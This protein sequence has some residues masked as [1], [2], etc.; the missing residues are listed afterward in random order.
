MEIVN[1]SSFIESFNP[2][3]FKGNNKAVYM[4]NSGVS[5]DIETTSFYLDNNY[6]VTTT[7]TDTKGCNMYI[8]TMANGDI[9]TKGRYWSEL[10]DMLTK[11]SIRL[12]LNKKRKLIIYCHNLSYEFQFMRAYFK[13]D[14]VFA[15]DNR[16]PLS[17]LTNEFIEFRCSYLLTNKSLAKLSEETKY[18]KLTGDLNYELLRHS[19][20]PLTDD[21][22]AYCYND[23][24]IVSDYINNEIKR[25]G[26]ITNI[27]LTS[28]GYVRRYCR[29]KCLKTSGYYKYIH[30]LNINDMNEYLELRR[31][32]QGGFTHANANH[33]NIQ[34]KDVHSYDFTSSYPYVMLVEEYPNSSAYKVPEMELK[35]ILTHDEYLYIFDISFD[36]I[37][38]T[39]D[40]ETPISYSRCWNIKN[41]VVN[42]GRVSC[43]EHIEMTTTSVD[44]EYITK[45]YAWEKCKI[46]NVLVYTKSL[47]PTPLR[48]CILDFYEG[49]TK[50][51]NV[52][53][54]EQEYSENKAM[55]N[56]IYGMTVTNT[57]KTQYTYN[58]DEWGIEETNY[59]ELLFKADK[60][61]NRFL[62]Y[63]WG[64]FVTAYARRNLFTAIYELK[65]DYIYSDTDSVKF[66]NLDK[67]IDYFKE[68]NKQVLMRIDSYGERA[69]PKTIDN[70]PKPIGVWDYEGKYDYF[71]TLGA[72]RYL[73]SVN[74]NYYLTVAGLNKKLGAEYISK[75]GGFKTFT[76]EMTIPTDYSGRLTHTY[77]DG[78]I[79]VKMCDYLGNVSEVEQINGVHLEKSDY[80]LS[81][82]QK[83][84]D[85]LTSI[86]KG[87]LV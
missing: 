57:I 82:A 69:T 54:K 61:S 46:T 14:R 45:F 22:L 78:T 65:D 49:K 32:F 31:A 50:L 27:P 43:A 39:M 70:I 33:V 38:Q 12:K 1:N 76:N 41:C 23:V 11:V 21:E 16:K 10:T 75:N 7:K 53:G 30:Q 85:F 56:S 72:K 15:I 60:T 3:N 86:N 17:A 68:Y 63:P 5:L 13:W 58:N 59:E 36:N 29:N 42:N 26:N 20:T 2:K 47:L 6:E 48:D 62:Y 34:I 55:L 18:N 74:N 44:M 83:Y 84:I 40:N 35:D 87:G 67:H 37:I 81:L 9:V 73:Y 8:W 19:E 52:V 79:N 80:H 25:N 24:L 66:K 64:V 71:K 51:K 28:T 4:Y 77:I